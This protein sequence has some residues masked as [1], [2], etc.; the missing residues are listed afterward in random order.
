M[1]LLPAEQQTFAYE[2]Q[3]VVAGLHEHNGYRH[4]S[5]FLPSDLFPSC[6]DFKRVVVDEIDGAS[7]LKL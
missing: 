1:R 6:D 7:V 4:F 2:N 3:K 5:L